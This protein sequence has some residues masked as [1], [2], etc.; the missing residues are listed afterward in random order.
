MQNAERR[1]QNDLIP[2]TLH[3]QGKNDSAEC[4]SLL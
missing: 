3:S 2:L 1:M 4:S